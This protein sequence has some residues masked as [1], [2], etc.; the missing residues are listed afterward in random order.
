MSHDSHVDCS[1]A[2]RY[3][4]QDVV[5]E[6]IAHPE[7]ILGPASDELKAQ[8]VAALKCAPMISP[9]EVAVL[10]EALTSSSEQE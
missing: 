8:M 4:V 2:R 5:N 6:L 1:G 7:W 10:C 3:P 9:A